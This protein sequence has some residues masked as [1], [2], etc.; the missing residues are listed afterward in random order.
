MPKIKHAPVSGPGNSPDPFWTVL[1]VPG[2]LDRGAGPSWTSHPG[3]NQAQ[4]GRRS[5]KGWLRGRTKRRAENKGKTYPNLGGQSHADRALPS[6]SSP[7][8]APR[9]RRPCTESGLHS[10]VFWVCHAISSNRRPCRHAP[11]RRRGGSSMRQDITASGAK[12]GLVADEKGGEKTRP[13][14]MVPRP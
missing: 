3:E 2:R 9:N 7:C 11:R 4:G 5:K 12:A 14:P 10:P 8:S 6:H 13:I 1:H